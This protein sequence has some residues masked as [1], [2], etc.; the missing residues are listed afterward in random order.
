[1]RK[2]RLK[3][4]IISAQLEDGFW[5]RL[6]DKTPQQSSATDASR[7]QSGDT[8]NAQAPWER[9]SSQQAQQVHLQNKTME[10]SKFWDILI[11]NWI[12]H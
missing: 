4:V 9:D 1:M 2:H 7:M 10:I 11:H 3:L 5:E 8:I 6:P 12:P